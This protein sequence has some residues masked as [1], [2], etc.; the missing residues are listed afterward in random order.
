M[1]TG[2]ALTN[3]TE[4]KIL[5]LVFR[6]VAYA[7]P[8]A[9]YAALFTGAPGEAGGGSEVSRGS[10]GRVAV[11]FGVAADGQVTNTSEVDFGEA[12]ADWG[13]IS[14]VAI[15][16]AATAGNMLVYGAMASNKTINNGDA[17]V[18]PPSTLT[19]VLD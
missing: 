5:N 11:T 18:W 3:Y 4:E 2:T 1:T 14:H 17:T 12:S 15:F 10:Y 16:D 9:V 7:P 8:A 13:T 19:V 6:N